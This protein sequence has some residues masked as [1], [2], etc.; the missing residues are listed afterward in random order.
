[1]SDITPSVLAPLVRKLA[2]RSPLGPEE[3]KALLCLPHREASCPVG[4]Y[5]VREGDKAPDFFLLLDGYAYR[6]K[7]GRNGARQILGVHLRGDLLDLQ[8]SLFDRADHNLQ[9]LTPIEL[10]YIPTRSIIDLAD[11]YPAIARA[12][13]IETLVDGSVSREWMMNIGRRTARQRIAHLFCELTLRQ[14]MAGIGG[15]PDYA[16]PLTQEQIGD[17]TGLTGV[18]VNRT[19]QALRENGLMTTGRRLVTIPD[20]AAL[21]AAGDFRSDYLHLPAVPPE[22]QDPFTAHHASAPA[23]ATTGLARLSHFARLQ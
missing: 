10:A 13:W 11:L 20:W 9:A 4:T 2:G 18:H 3:R 17:A 19:L 21:Q 16:W 12:L 6:S 5:L 15:G 1:M 14:K 8:N 7:N 23:A 22:M